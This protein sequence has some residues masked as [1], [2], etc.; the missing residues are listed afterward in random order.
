MYKKHKMI[1]SICS[2]KF[3]MIFMMW[4]EFLWKPGGALYLGEI[5]RTLRSDYIGGLNIFGEII[6]GL[7][8][9]PALL[10]KKKHTQ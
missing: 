10:G 2:L 8:V 6:T 4:R 9:V 3:P 1:P 7:K 5:L